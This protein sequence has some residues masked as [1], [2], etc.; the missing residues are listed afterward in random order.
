MVHWLY[1]H[2]HFPL[3]TP[4]CLTEPLTFTQHGY[5]AQ[6]GLIQTPRYIPAT[7]EWDQKT[8]RSETDE[9]VTFNHFKTETSLARSKP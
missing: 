3:K 4:Q 8:S 2:F 9:K 5:H 7:R 6:M 1:S